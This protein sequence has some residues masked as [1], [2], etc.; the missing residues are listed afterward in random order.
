MNPVNAIPSAYREVIDP[1]IARARE[2]LEAGEPLVPFAFVG[3][4]A[5]RQM[6]PVPL[7]T[8]DD[9]SKD[10]AAATIRRTAQAIA[11]DF[12][13][14][15]MESWGLPPEKVAEYEAIVAEYGSVGASPWR[16]DVVA[17]SLETRHGLW[18]AQAPITRKGRSKTKRTFGEVAFRYFAEVEGRL[19]GLLPRDDAHD[20]AKPRLH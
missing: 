9:R 6:M 17:F 14:M 11:A 1:L 16:V 2:F 7:G 4:F 8:G 3:N 18:F 10:A 12:V 20:D 5:N 15:V 19:A 13:F